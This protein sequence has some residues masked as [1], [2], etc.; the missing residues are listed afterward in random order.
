MNQQYGE[1]DTANAAFFARRF[2]RPTG[3][4]SPSDTQE[5]SKPILHCNYCDRVERRSNHEESRCWTKKKD[6]KQQGDAR[7][8]IA[9]SSQDW[10]HG[11]AFA[12]LSLL[13]NVKNKL[14]GMPIRKLRNI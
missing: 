12:S 9:S 10:P 6:S 5:P 2:D 13:S 7:A 8:N 4:A 14:I 1:V 11:Y 3:V